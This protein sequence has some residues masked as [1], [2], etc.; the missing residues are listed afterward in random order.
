MNRYTRGGGGGE[1]TGEWRMDEEDF[2]YLEVPDHP[3]EADLLL[4]SLYFV[5]GGTKV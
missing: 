1:S 5:A 3:M 2:Y 4:L